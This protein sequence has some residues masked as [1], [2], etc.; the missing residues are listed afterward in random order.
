LNIV[1]GPDFFSRARRLVHAH[2]G[3]TTTLSR[4]SIASVCTETIVDPPIT[5]E[6]RNM[7]SRIREAINFTFSATTI[8]FALEAIVW[9]AITSAGGDLVTCIIANIGGAAIGLYLAIGLCLLPL[10]G[11]GFTRSLRLT[12][13]LAV[14]I[15]CIFAAGFGSAPFAA[16]AIGL[17]VVLAMAA[18][19][20]LFLILHDDDC[21]PD[22]SAAM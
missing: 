21:E 9:W 2:L 16:Y 13:I 12:S 17:I 22:Y 6:N 20:R 10:P 7:H 19:R 8:A 3:Y 11:Y 4:L 15:G 5:Q 18:L 1:L 14:L